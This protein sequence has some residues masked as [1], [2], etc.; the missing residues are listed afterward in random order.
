MEFIRKF[1][2]DS[3]KEYIICNSL[4]MHYVLYIITKH[5]NMYLKRYIQNQNMYI[6]VKI[7]T[8]YLIYTL[9]SKIYLF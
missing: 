1:E 3:D 9:R 4:A 6:I 8:I 2:Y 7:V 5:V